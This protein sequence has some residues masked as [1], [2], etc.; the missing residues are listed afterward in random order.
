[1][2]LPDT[3]VTYLSERKIQHS[4]RSESNMTC[5]VLEQFELPAGYTVPK[6]DLL[7][8]LSPGYPDVAPDMW[9]FDP[10]VRLAS[11]ASIPATDHIEH[12]LG[13]AWQR[14]SRHFSVGQWKS[15]IDSLESYVALIRRELG[16]HVSALAA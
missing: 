8:R 10:P 3:D 4:V 13:R 9:W 14:W 1:M 15:G 6:S 5:V 2:S 12:H 16:R 7:I 11:G